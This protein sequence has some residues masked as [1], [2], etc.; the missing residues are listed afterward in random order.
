MAVS[1]SMRLTESNAEIKA[2]PPKRSIGISNGVRTI[3]TSASLIIRAPPS[4]KRIRQ[5]PISRSCFGKPKGSVV[6]V[7]IVRGKT[8][9]SNPNKRIE[10]FSKYALTSFFDSI[11]S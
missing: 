7:V 1:E 8:A 3:R 10:M 4:S 5:I 2:N 6:R 11:N 9:S